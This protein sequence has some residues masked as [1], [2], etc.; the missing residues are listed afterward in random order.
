MKKLKLSIT[1][2]KVL[3]TIYYLNRQNKYPLPEGV[4]KILAGIIDEETYSLQDCPTFSTL[5][6][7]NSKKV[8]RY[9][10]ALQKEGYVH[11]RLD[12][13][14]NNLYFEISK[15][16]KEVVELF[17]EKHKKPY[18]QKKRPLKQTIIQM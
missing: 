6:S 15:K 13:K 9:L 17:H 14:T 12:E 1:H 10:A 5:I 2:F 3:D 4:Y 18:I 16:G 7:F 11:K 8:C